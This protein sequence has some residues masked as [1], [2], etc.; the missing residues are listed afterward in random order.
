MKTN[1]IVRIVL[2]SIVIFLLLSLLITFLLVD[3]Y[4]ADGKVHVDSSANMEEPFGMVNR[5]VASDQV[6]NIEIEWA[7]GSISIQ[8][9]D[10]IA[11]IEIYEF[12]QPD[13]EYQM[14][15]KQSGQTLKIQYS[16]DSIEF[17]S[18]GVTADASKELVIKVPVDWVCNSLEIDAAS[19]SVTVSDLTIYEFDFDGASGDCNVT[20]CNVN[21]MDI[22]T[23]SGNVTFVGTLDMLDCSAASAD[24]SI[25]VMNNPTTIDVDAASGDLEL[26][27]PENAGFTCHMDTMSGEFESDFE[28]STNKGVYVHGDGS[29]QINVSAMSGDVC[30][31]KD[32]DHHSNQDNGHHAE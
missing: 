21:E 19:A 7:A 28:V 16:K 26:I 6:R 1:A 11:D 30:I 8:P 31:Y 32:I 17:P 13:C 12:A 15:C 23:A 24:C 20:N 9:D 27:L 3:I 4:I 22:D 14:V 5:G 18:F 29:C 2:F 25:T 10:S